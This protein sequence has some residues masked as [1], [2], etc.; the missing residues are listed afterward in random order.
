MGHARFSLRRYNSKTKQHLKWVVT[1]GRN[2]SGK[3]SRKF[4]RTRGEAEVYLLQMRTDATNLGLRAASIPDGL[5]IEAL[6]AAQ[7]LSPL[8]RSLTN[9][10][11]YY[12]DHLEQT[13]KSETVANLIEPFLERKRL[14]GLSDR[15]LGDLT[16]KLVKLKIKF[17]EEYAA[18]V[19]TQAIQEWIDEMKVSP[20]TQN[21]FRRVIGVFFSW[22]VKNHYAAHNP[23]AEIA[24]KKVKDTPVPIFTPQEVAT[25][26]NFASESFSELVPFLALGFFAGIR[27]AELERMKWDSVHFDSG[28]VLVDVASSKSARKRFIPIREILAQWLAPLKQKPSRPICPKNHKDRLDNFRSALKRERGIAWPQNGMRHSYASYTLAHEKDAGKLA[29][30]MGHTDTKLIFKNYRELVPASEG[31]AYWEI[32][33][34]S[35]GSKI[36]KMPA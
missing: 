8:G 14:D 4:F 12:I 21:N 33:P 16:A 27:T 3:P 18:T 30:E 9:A 35:T 31:A 2:E 24:E 7:R 6:K 15:Y 29:I 20:I 23:V 32:A 17:G 25:T 36:I 19:T 10:V 22:C 28:N 26:L 11:D 34:L 1:G 13:E 5:K